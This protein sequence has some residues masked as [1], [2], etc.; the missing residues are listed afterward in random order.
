[1]SSLGYP[2]ALA[3][4]GKARGEPGSRRPHHPRSSDTWR[5]E[6]C[7][8]ALTLR[9]AHRS[10]LTWYDC[11]FFGEEKIPTAAV[12]IYGSQGDARSMGSQAPDKWPVRLRQPTNRSLSASSVTSQVVQV[13]GFFSIEC[14]DKWEVHT[15]MQSIIS[16]MD[17]L[18]TCKPPSPLVHSGL[19][20]LA[21]KKSNGSCKC[22]RAAYGQ[23]AAARLRPSQIPTPRP[24]VACLSIFAHFRRGSLR[25]N[26][27]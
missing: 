19:A 10:V 1:M 3:H 27:V 5:G 13:L 8:H 7:C 6:G 12:H 15:S 20:V 22:G 24:L 21:T 14:P 16:A 4:S 2:I 17:Y 25:I 23:P 9:W 18:G 11:F 26:Q